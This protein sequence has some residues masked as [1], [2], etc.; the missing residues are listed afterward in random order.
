MSSRLDKYY[1]EQ[2]SKELNEFKYS[3]RTKR[4]EELYKEINKSEIDNFE[5]QSNATV[6]VDN[7]S[8]NIDVEKIK[9]ILDTKYNEPKK[10]K[11]FRIEEEKIEDEKEITKEYDIN[12]ILEKAKEEKS[13]KYEDVRLKKLRDTQFDILKNLDID[14]EDDQNQEKKLENLIKTCC[15]NE[16]NSKGTEDHLDLLSDLR[17]DDDS[18]ILEGQKE[19][20][21]EVKEEIE[22]DVVDEDDDNYDDDNYNDTVTDEE[23]INSFYTASNKIN[24][25]DLEEKMDDDKEFDP[26][27]DEDSNFFVKILI[28]LIILIF[29]VGLIFI[30]KTL[31]F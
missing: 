29:I 2:D 18:D 31:Y 27:I 28:F 3:S 14:K 10:R 15:Y 25:K 7:N 30:I 8:N 6:L 12:V 9:K 19:V 24:K 5:V 22:E 16:L 17:G 21:D 26:I 20:I 1:Q 11:S 13:E 4:N 23:L